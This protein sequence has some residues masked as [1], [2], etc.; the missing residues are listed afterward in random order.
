[1]VDK[2]RNRDDSLKSRQSRDRE[3]PQRRSMEHG[4]SSNP[5]R[6]ASGPSGH[7]ERSG[8]SGGSRGTSGAQRGSD[9]NRKRG[10][11]DEEEES[12]L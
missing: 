9:I 5:S 2:N 11:E 1:M 3:D 10:S 7:S 4:G 6:S 12:D 8:E